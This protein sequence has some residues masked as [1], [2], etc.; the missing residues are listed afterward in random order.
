MIKFVG[1]RGSTPIIVQNRIPSNTELPTLRLLAYS[2]DAV[3]TEIEIRVLEAETKRDVD[4][5]HYRM[6]IQEVILS[7]DPPQSA[8]VLFLFRI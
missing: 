8:K 2:R 1:W 4:I 6:L 5:D 3:W 7:H